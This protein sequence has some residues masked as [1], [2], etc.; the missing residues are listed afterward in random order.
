MELEG[1]ATARMKCS[2]KKDSPLAV[3]FSARGERGELTVT[4]PVGPHWGHQLIVKTAREEKSETVPGDTSYTHQLRAFAAAMRGE[5]SFPTDAREG[6]I[7]MRVI[8]DVYRA[9]GLPRAASDSSGIGLRVDTSAQLSRLRKKLPPAEE[10]SP[11]RTIIAGLPTTF[12][13]FQEK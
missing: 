5:S 11:C 4:N 3:S 10:S 9:A 13:I 8:D 1:G 7:N 2:M 12:P 6:I